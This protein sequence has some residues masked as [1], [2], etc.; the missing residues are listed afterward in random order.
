MVKQERKTPKVAGILGS[1]LKLEGM[2]DAKALPYSKV[3]SLPRHAD[4]LL[5]PVLNCEDEFQA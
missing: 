3:V 2:S 5:N 1:D 4:C